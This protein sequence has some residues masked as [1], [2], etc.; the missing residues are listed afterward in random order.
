MFPFDDPA[1]T[2]FCKSWENAV[3]AIELC[4]DL[5]EE[6]IESLVTAI[7]ADK[8]SFSDIRNIFPDKDLQV[9]HKYIADAYDIPD[10]LFLLTGGSGDLA[11]PSMPLLLYFQEK[12]DPYSPFYQ[13]SEKDR[14]TL[15][16]E[17]KNILYRLQKE[18]KLL[19]LT[20]K[21]VELSEKSL[22]AANRSNRIATYA[23]LF[24]GISAIAS[25]IAL[26]LAL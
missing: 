23:A 7:S 18:K 22:A 25:I 2:N 8:N 6:E 21:S 1:Q 11:Y 4:P 17:G 9:L 19:T 13:L 10:S 24:S 16:P 14:F 12:P 15:V 3:N 20:E 5:T 26:Y